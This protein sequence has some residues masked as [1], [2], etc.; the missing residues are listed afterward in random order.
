MSLARNIPFGDTATLQ[1]RAE[2]FNVLNHVNLNNPNTSI[3]SAAAGT[4]T[5]AGDPRIIQ[6]GARLSF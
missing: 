6:F 3:G 1:I 2:A 4:I 5:G